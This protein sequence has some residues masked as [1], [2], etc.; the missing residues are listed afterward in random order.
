MQTKADIRKFILEKRKGEDIE[1]ISEKIV[2]RLLSLHEFAECDTVFCY[3]SVGDEIST[4]KIIRSAINTGKRVA[5]P[6]TKSDFSL[7]FYYYDIGTPMQRGKFNIPEPP[8]TER[9]RATERS[10]CIVPALAIN[11]EGHRVGYGKGC[12]DRFLINFK[13][14]TVGLAA[15]YSI[16][17]FEADV[18]DI[19]LDAAVTEKRIIRF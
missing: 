9:A 2:K 15:E 3:F 4:E 19:S 17:P 10:L 11:E 8:R 1:K 12:Y 18:T 14:K 6:V 13:G 5:L 7:D 16:L